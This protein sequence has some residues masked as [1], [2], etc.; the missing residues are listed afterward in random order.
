VLVG[1]PNAGKSTLL[2]ALC[3]TARSIVSPVA[4]TTRDV[5]WAE[6]ALSRG[7]VRI[8]DAAGLEEHPPDSG[9]P[10]PAARIAR[11]MHEHALAAVESADFVVL[12][13]DATDRRPRLTPPRA[14]DIVVLTKVDL[15]EAAPA[16][17]DQKMITVSAQTGRN[18]SELKS[19]LEAMAFGSGRGGSALALNARHLRSIDE[20]QTAL[21][22][23][24]SA[25]T[26]AGPEVVAL[27]LRE[28]LDALGR[29]LGE[30]TPDEV[31]GRV[32]ATFCV[33]K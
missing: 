11:L 16:A 10:S 12:V 6:A 18:M 26:S 8:V 23:A 15:L 20:A 22:R 14:A 19:V 17:A 9:D 32:F 5:I 27:E 24:Q 2:N 21:S 4:G 1:R 25:A 28:S 31:L 13:H 30:M 29:I 7:I 33:G 3:G